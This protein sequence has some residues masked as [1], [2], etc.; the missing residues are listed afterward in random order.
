MAKSGIQHSEQNILNH[1]FD[2]DFGALVVE[3]STYNPITDKLERQ[4]AIQ[5]NGSFT[6]DITGST[7]VI[8]Q[9]IGA[10]TYQ[11]TYDWSTNPITESVWVQV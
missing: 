4:V 3:P 8:S 10:I 1:C 5:G 11:K 9:I 6:Y 7:C 2:G